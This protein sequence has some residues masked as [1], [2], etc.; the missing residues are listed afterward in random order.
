MNKEF[1]FKIPQL[2]NYKYASV[3]VVASR[4]VNLELVSVTRK[5]VDVDI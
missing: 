2:I 3:F 5:K 4:H 1:Y